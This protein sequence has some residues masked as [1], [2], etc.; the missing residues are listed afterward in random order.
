MHKEN[1]DGI[2]EAEFL[3]QAIDY[4]NTDSPLTPCK[5]DSDFNTSEKF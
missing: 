4:K 5:R 1:I 2:L 3:T